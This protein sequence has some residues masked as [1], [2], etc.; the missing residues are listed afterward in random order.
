MGTISFKPSVGSYELLELVYQRYGDRVY[1]LCLR[2]LV[3]VRQAE[4]ATVDVFVRFGR[5]LASQWDDQRTEL[6]LRELAIDAALSQLQEPGKEAPAAAAIL[7]SNGNGSQSAERL[8]PAMLDRLIARLPATERV[9]F[10][11]HDVEGVSD[12]AAA[13]YLQMTKTAMR[14][15]LSKA[16]LELRRLW[17]SGS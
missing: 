10:V 15:F 8:E 9:V 12:A 16:R 11:L 5:C 14:R 4:S 6:C 7:T 17:R 3:D 1:S 13:T 2:L